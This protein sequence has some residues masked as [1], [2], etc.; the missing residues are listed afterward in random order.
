[1]SSPSRRLPRLG[2]L[3]LVTQ[4]PG[5]GAG[6]GG[7]DQNGK[8]RILRRIL[9]ADALKIL[10]SKRYLKSDNNMATRGRGMNDL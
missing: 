6:S 7:A 8:E 9:F 3:M 1:M 4:G 5:L 2:S 10:I